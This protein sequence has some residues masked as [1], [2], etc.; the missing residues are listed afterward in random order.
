[1]LSKTVYGRLPRAGLM[2]IIIFYGLSRNTLLLAIIFSLLMRVICQN[3]KTKQNNS[4]KTPKNNLAL[5][6][7]PELTTRE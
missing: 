4:P 2:D 5:P 3:G 1:M 7:I 6:F